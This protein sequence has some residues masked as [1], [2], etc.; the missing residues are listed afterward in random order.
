MNAGFSLDLF[1]VVFLLGAV[2]GVFL[3]LLLAGVRRRSTANSLLAVAMVAF[4]IDLLTAAYYNLGLEDRLPHFIGVDYLL[5]FLYGPLIYFYVKAM[6]SSS[7]RLRAMDW[8]QFLPIVLVALYMIPFYAQSGV[9]KLHLHASP[10][11]HPWNQRLTLI[12]Y[13][14]FVYGLGYLVGAFVLLRRHR[15]RVR[16]TFSNVEHITLHWLRNLLVGGMVVWVISLISYVVWLRSDGGSGA[17]PM[18]GFDDVVLLAVA[19]FVYAIGYLGLRQPEI[20]WPDARRE[21]S[22]VERP[23]G[24]RPRYARSG[25]DSETAQRIMRE[26]EAHMEQT[27]A[28]RNAG[29]KLNDLADAISVSTHHL[30]EALNSIVGQS[31][32]YFVNGYRVREVKERVARGDAEKHTLLSIALDAGF[33]SKSSFNAVFKKH[34]GMTP[35]EFR[36]SA[37]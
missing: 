36:E 30:S 37:G 35:S 9:S 7:G 11:G 12:N 3:A 10:E 4:S 25:L 34:T 21:D 32:Y 13:V 31:F 29:L 26:L 8:L 17:G 6:D 1:S 18:E 22:T 20:F 28:Y 16:N 14:K 27:G 33:N 24:L 19:V 15:R 23:D 2:Q 5:P